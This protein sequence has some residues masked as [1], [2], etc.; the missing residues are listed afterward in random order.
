MFYNYEQLLEKLAVASGLAKEELERKV[1][2]KRAKLSGLIS[3][4]GAAQIIAT[5]LGINFEKQKLKINELVSGMRNIGFV[6]KAIRIFPVRSY[7]KNGREGKVANMIVADETGNA[8]LVLWDVNHISLIENNEIKENDNVLVSGASIRN[9]EAH[10]TGFSDIKLS[11]EILGNVKTER[12]YAEK[13]LSEVKAGEYVKAR[14]FIVQ[15]FEPRA[16][17][18]CPSCSKK[19]LNENGQVKCAEHGAVL[20]LKRHLVS[21]VLDDGSE[22]MRITLFSEQMKM[23]GIS[24]EMEEFSRQRQEFVGKEMLFSGSIKQNKFFNNLEMS[25]E[26]AKEINVDEILAELE[27]KR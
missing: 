4:E 9:G 8:R 15:M 19:V 2:A 24:S 16:F 7:N 12:D 21:A 17:E 13:L 23:L 14:A 3:K 1:E 6:A 26:S 20:P 10:L 5:E 18:V 27:K 25:V 11:S 22:N